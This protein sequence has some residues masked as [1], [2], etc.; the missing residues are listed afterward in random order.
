LKAFFDNFGGGSFR[1]GLYR[2]VHAADLDPWSERIGLG[3]PEWRHCICFGYDWLGRAFAL[4]P[5]RPEHGQ[6]GVVMM[7]PGANEAYA[8][9]S[10][11]LTFHETDLMEFTDDVLGSDFYGQ[12]RAR[13]GAMPLYEQCIGYKTPLFLGGQ[14]DAANLEVSDIDVYWHI[15]GQ[16]IE[17]TRGLPPGSPVRIKSG[18]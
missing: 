3:F 12:W 15:T 7:D 6:P 4:D 14:D 8:I 11:I 16:L 5:E 13:R 1:G 9:P 10:N 17:R 2:V 18:R